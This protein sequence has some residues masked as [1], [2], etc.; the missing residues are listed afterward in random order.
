MKY[1][2]R[3]WATQNWKNAYN[4]QSEMMHE[5][6]KILVRNS[7]VF[8]SEAQRQRNEMLHD[9]K[10]SKSHALNQCENAKNVIMQ[11]NRPE[12]NRHI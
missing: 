11:E 4:V 6:N 8:Y 7:V 1:L 12:M 5:I 9:P 3:G 10:C 2:I